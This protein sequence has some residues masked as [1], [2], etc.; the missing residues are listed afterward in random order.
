MRISDWSSDVCSSDLVCQSRTKP[1]GSPGSISNKPGAM[2]SPYRQR[3]SSSVGN[4]TVRGH[5][6]VAQLSVLSRNPG[7]GGMRQKP[8]TSTRASATASRSDEHTSELPSLMRLLYALF[9]LHLISFS[10]FFF[11]F[12]FFFFFS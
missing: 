1:F 5:G 9:F 2:Y 12:F 6:S 11:L 4:C 3:K 7:T 8:R 10:F